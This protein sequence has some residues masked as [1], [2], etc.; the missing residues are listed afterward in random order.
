[1][2][3]EPFDIRSQFGNDI[4]DPTLDVVGIEEQQ[5]ALEQVEPRQGGV[6]YGEWIDANY[7]R[8]ERDVPRVA[9]NPP[10]S[11]CPH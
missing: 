5:T 4:F 11:P 3:D 9:M 1:M 7:R 10:L 8:L 6:I 2:E